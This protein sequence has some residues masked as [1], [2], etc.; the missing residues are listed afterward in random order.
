MS[1][2]RSTLSPQYTYSIES[3]RYRDASGR[4]VPQQAVR[5]ALDQV[6]DGAAGRMRAVAE[7]LQA[8]SISVATWQLQSAQIVKSTHLAAAASASGGW[9]TMSQADLGWTGQRIR[10]QYAFLANFAAEI[11]SGKQPLDGRLLVRAEMYGHAGRA[12]ARE[13]ER[14]EARLAG[15][16]HERNVLGAADHCAGCL[17]ASAQGVVPIGTLVPIGQRDCRVNCHCVIRPERDPR[18]EQL[19]A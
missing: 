7:Q 9:A 15:W 10:Q 13:M 18:A 14:R 5:A 19:A 1:E 4:F 2:Q 12:T 11:A 8:G 3:A 6:L 17:G 16:T